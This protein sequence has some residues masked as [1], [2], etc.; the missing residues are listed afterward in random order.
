MRVE[1]LLEEFQFFRL[2]LNL[3]KVLNIE[4]AYAGN[5]NDYMIGIYENCINYVQ[6]PKIALLN[7]TR[8]LL[9]MVLDIG[10]RNVFAQHVW[11]RFLSYLEQIVYWSNS[12]SNLR[13]LL[14]QVGTQ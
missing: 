7:V 11:T 8:K 4:M 2:F 13:G 12:Y 5:L 9:A 3:F 10:R 6:N 14:K 1:T